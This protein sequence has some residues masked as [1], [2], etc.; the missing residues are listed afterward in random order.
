MV[1][2][3]TKT[4]VGPNTRVIVV[5]DGEQWEVPI[6]DLD[7]EHQQQLYDTLWAL[8]MEQVTP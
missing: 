2:N 4:V 1:T 6:Q 3:A 5:A 7:R 8:L